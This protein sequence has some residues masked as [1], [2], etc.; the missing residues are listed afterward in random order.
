MQSFDYK[1]SLVAV[2]T[3]YCGNIVPKELIRKCICCE[4]P[5]NNCGTVLLIN[6]NQYIPNVMLHETC[7]DKITDPV[8]LCDDIREKHQQYIKLKNIFK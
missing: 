6:N 3:Y 4:Q 7:A 1:D 5:I 2:K 8:A